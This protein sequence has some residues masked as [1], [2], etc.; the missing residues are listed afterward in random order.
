MLK[1]LE[2]RTNVQETNELLKGYNL[3]GFIS[4]AVT[5]LFRRNLKSLLTVKFVKI[6]IYLTGNK[7]IDGRHEIFG[8]QIDVNKYCDFAKLYDER[9]E[10]SV[11]KEYLLTLIR[12]S[13]LA[14]TALL[15][16]S[17][18]DINDAYDECLKRK[19]V[20]EYYYK[21]KLF[22]SPSHNY[23]F[24]LLTIHDVDKYEI[25]EILFDRKKQEIVRRKCYNSWTDFYYLESAF[26]KEKEI[27]CY[28]FD[29]INKE[30]CCSVDNIISV[31]QP[32]SYVNRDR[33]FKY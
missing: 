20:Y 6:S 3:K 15:N 1:D 8:N 26:W 9:L 12:D 10:M 5:K 31:K 13:L 4:T 28:K 30:F 29:T 17:P 18:T 21:N 24:G 16:L 11:R 14:N 22:R 32:E 2:L 7:D 27:F 23:Y 19:V 25:W 33:Y